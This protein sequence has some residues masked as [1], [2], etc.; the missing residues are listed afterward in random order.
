MGV[1]PQIC[2]HEYS[3]LVD[4]Y[5]K[6]PYSENVRAKEERPAVLYPREP[7]RVPET[8]EF[9]PKLRNIFGTIHNV[10]L[11]RER[12]EDLV[13]LSDVLHVLEPGPDEVE[14]VVVGR[15]VDDTPV[16]VDEPG[17]VGQLVIVTWHIVDVNVVPGEDNGHIVAWTVLAPRAVLV[18]RVRARAED[19]PHSPDSVAERRVV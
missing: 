18:F 7:F 13:V 14:L 1:I 9:A 15:G 3:V 4:A 11:E 8:Y 19:P 12:E 5:L 6:A 2:E 17:L 16:G 10:F